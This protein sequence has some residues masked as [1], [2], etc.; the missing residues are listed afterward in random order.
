MKRINARARAQ[1]FTRII[2]VPAHRAHVLNEAA[3]RRRTPL[4]PEQQPK[5]TLRQQPYVMRTPGP[6]GSISQVAWLSGEQGF[7]NFWLKRRPP[8][9]KPA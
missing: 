2:K 7:V 5:L 9:T 8:S 3:V 6:Y 1:V 4:P